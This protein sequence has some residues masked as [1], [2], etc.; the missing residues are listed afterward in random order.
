MKY[1]RTFLVIIT[2][3]FVVLSGLPEFS[4]AISYAYEEKIHANLQLEED[5]SYVVVVRIKWNP[6]L[7]PLKFNHDAMVNEL[8]REAAETQESIITFLE[9]KGAKILDTAWLVNEILIEADANIIW[10]LATLSTVEKIFPNFELTIPKFEIGA[11]AEFMVA[12]NSPSWNLEKVR[13]PEV[14]EEF[15]IRG[16][17][18]R[19]AT[20]EMAGIDISHPE[21]A[22]T[23][24]TDNPSDPLYPGGWIE[25]NSIGQIVG[26]SVPHYTGGHGTA[27]Y[28][29][30][31]GQTMGMAPNAIGMHAKIAPYYRS[32]VKAMQWVI[33]PYDQN[34]NPAGKPA[35]V[36]NHSY[37]IPEDY[38]DECVGAIRNMW[39]FNHFVVAIIGNKGEGTSEPPGSVYET[40]AVGATDANDNVA[41]FSSGRVVYKTEWGNPM[42]DW[43]NQWTKPDLSAPGVNVTVPLPGNQSGQGDGTS[44]AAPHVAG[45]A[46]LMLSR[47]PSLRVQE[48]EDILKETAVWYD[49]YSSQRPDTR[50]GW[51]RIDA[52]RAVLL[53]GFSATLV[54]PQGNV[55]G[56]Y[57]IAIAI[58]EKLAEIRVNVIIEERSAL[59]IENTVWGD[60]WDK[61]WNEA[62]GYGWDMVWY[63]FSG[64]PE[65]LMNYYLAN[66]TPPDGYN[67]MGW[68]STDADHFLIGGMEATGVGARKDY[69]DAWQYEWMRDPP[70]VIIYYPSPYQCA[71]GIAFNLHHPV[72]RYR[73]VR[74]AIARAIP[75][76][77]I[78][79][80]VLPNR[81]IVDPKPGIAAV[82]PS[83][84]YGGVQLLNSE[85]PL[86]TYDLVK[87][88][89]YLDMWFYSQT[90]TD[91]TKGCVGD[92]NFD[93]KVDL[94]D[95]FL[96]GEEFNNAPYD[97]PYAPYTIDA[98]FDNNGFVGGSDYGLW[99]ATAGN[100]YPY[101]WAGGSASSS[102]SESPEEP[103]AMPPESEGPYV[104]VYVDQPLGYISG[105]PPHRTVS[106]DIIIEVTN[107]TDGSA[108][109]IVGWGMNIQVDPD[110]LSIN[111]ASGAASG[112]FLWEFADVAFLPPPTML[113]GNKNSTTGYWDDLA[114]IF[115]PLPPLGAG[116]GTSY[117][118]SSNLLVTLE[119]TSKS[120]S[121][122]SLIDLIDVAYLTPDRTWHPVDE[123][124]DGHYNTPPT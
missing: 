57:D 73:Y 10:E 72:L 100:E 61:T 56:T 95:R 120:K 27:T 107:I 30:I 28:G 39:D 59:G 5:K 23:L 62:P 91:H 82:L 109:G 79:T 110:V 94:D 19:V 98:D 85:L 32:A 116:N 37:G 80:D 103:P 88:Q 121:K 124:V 46:V 2:V 33:A 99:L 25:F 1:G 97:I 69:F 13:A 35:N 55:N 38:K 44:F 4:P 24:W 17:N 45:A 90:G 54:I 22:G 64:E 11:N 75:Y 41:N 96:W 16:E 58:K 117:P 36:S 104:K 9:Q 49:R 42:P 105:E 63:E 68:N 14:W 106:V 89:R 12:G 21:I 48:I 47:N 122:Y 108:E 66:A 84:Y 112:Y 6:N 29:L 118:T 65:D 71:R 102:S 3:F 87:A 113:Q 51:G 52:Y 77:D 60:Y 93:G 43:P 86:Y 74:G 50:Y 81:G 114:E 119:F 67:I 92:A 34:G 20:V 15:G 111:G 26:G 40:I 18:V 31:L 78:F 53:A 101:D 7:E 8:K 115:V 70:A 83:Y 76:A 123:V